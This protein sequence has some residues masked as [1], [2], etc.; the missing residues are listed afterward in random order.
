MIGQLNMRNKKG[1]LKNV[2]IILNAFENNAQYGYGYGAYSNGYYEEDVR[3]KNPWSKFKK[4][5]KE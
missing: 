1:E 3:K 2:S 5:K 4:R